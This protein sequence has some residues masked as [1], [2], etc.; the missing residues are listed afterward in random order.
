LMAAFAFS[1]L[2]ADKPTKGMHPPEGTS[3]TILKWNTIALETMAGPTYDPMIA[4]RIFAM[5]HIAMHDAMNSIDPVYDTYLHHPVQKKADPVAAVSAAAYAVLVETFPKKKE[6]LDAALA[7]ATS[8]VKSAEARKAGID[9]GT[10]I[11][12]ATVA[13]RAKDGAFQHPVAEIN[14]PKVPGMYQPV[15]PTPFVYTPFWAT[16]PT[17]ALESPY[18]FRVAPMAALASEEYARHFNEV[19]A[20][21]AKVNSTRTAE[22]TTI[23]KFWYEFSEIGWNRIAATLA[24]DKNLDAHATARLL[25]LVNM[26]LADSYIA[27]W[28]SKFFYNFWRPY[29]AIR[30]AATDGNALTTQD[31]NWEPLLNTPPVQDY[32]STHSVLG[33][34]AATVLAELLGGKTAFTMTSTSAE[35]ANS[36]RSFANVWQAAVEN[37]DSRIFAG[38]HFRFSCDQGLDMG[39]K[40]GTWVHQ[41]QLRPKTVPSASR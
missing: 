18:Q 2:G 3:S 5:V 37:A 7:N 32:P 16:L 9:L 23:A 8:W 35:P 15:P 24:A 36:S 25:A 41:T 1:A 30:A 26:A 40:I 21:G 11:G 39:K 28:D 17:F 19:K 22:E 13:H 4:S 31:D 34:A 33:S 6:S 29:T 27:G 14:N 38:L 20:K 12:K 10:L